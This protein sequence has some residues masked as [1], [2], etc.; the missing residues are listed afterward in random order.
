MMSLLAGRFVR[1]LTGILLVASLGSCG[2]K[3]DLY[4]PEPDKAA[5][6]DQTVNSGNTGSNSTTG[7]SPNTAVEAD[8]DAKKTAD[9]PSEG[10]SAQP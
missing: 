1:V 5:T 4:L 3:G 8:E 10:T 7:T 6:A 2:L 9:K